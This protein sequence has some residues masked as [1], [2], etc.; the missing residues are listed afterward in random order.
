MPDPKPDAAPAEELHPFDRE[1]PP[2]GKPIHFKLAWIQNN[3]GHVDKTGQ[4]K[5]GS[6]QYKHMQEHGLLQVLKPLLRDALCA[7][8]PEALL[9]EHNGNHM[10]LDYS[11]E[12]SCAETGDSITKHFLGEGVDS[13]DKAS[14][15]GMT[16]GMKYSLQKFFLIPTEKLDE[17]EGS[18][19]S[20]NTGSTRGTGNT[21]AGKITQADAKKLHEAAQAAIKEK[22]LDANK[23]KGQLQAQF[24][25][26]KVSDLKASDGAAFGK[27]L[28]DNIADAPSQ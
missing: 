17:P 21:R 8:T 22:R 23:V 13:S 5:F 6:T 27:W 16:G 11:I 15:K 14:Y 7:C 10:T 19:P 4:V 24:G 20:E 2:V 9:I 28:V 12:L 3:A 25:V 1:N 18:A 26:D